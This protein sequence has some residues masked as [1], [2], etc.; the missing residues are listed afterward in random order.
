MAGIDLSVSGLAS[1]FDW[2]NI[3]DQLTEVERQPQKAVLT[4]QANIAKRR[5]ALGQISTRLTDLKTK[6]EALQQAS[7]YTGRTAST[8]DD[9]V[10]TASATNSAITGGFQVTV[11]SMAKAAS[12]KSSNSGIFSQVHGSDITRNTNASS[13]PTLGS[14]NWGPTLSTGTLSLSVKNPTTQGVVTA[15]IQVSSSDTLADIFDDIYQATGIEAT[16]SAATDKVTFTPPAGT[17]IILGA[18]NDTSNLLGCL[19][20]FT[21]STAGQSAVSSSG[22][23]SLRLGST[24]ASQPLSTPIAP[25]T[26]TFTINGTS[27]SYSTSSTLASLI[28]DINDSSAGVVATYDQSENCIV[29]RNKEPG[30]RGITVADTSPGNLMSALGLLS[31]SLTEGSDLEFSI[32]GGATQRSRSNTITET[33]SG[34]TGITFTAKKTGTA[35]VT[36]A[37]DTATMSKAITDLV[38]AASNVQSLISS[39]TVSNRDAS[40]KVTSGILAYDQTVFQL[41]S[42]LRSLMMPQISGPSTVIRSLEDLGFSTS[43]YSNEIKVSN[44][45]KLKDAL[46]ANLSEVKAFLA[47]SSTGLAAKIAA[48]AGPMVDDISGTIPSRQKALTE[49][50]KRLDG[51]LEAMERRVQANRERLLAS[52][53]AMEAAQAKSSQQLQFL[54]QKLANG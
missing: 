1:G 52:F 15:S 29:L 6:A 39:L 10:I 38:T 27:V 51:Q 41:G 33:E 45:G 16:Y 23:G 2:K 4:E 9:T 30:N 32:N 17:S 11:T 22:I 42:T 36:T 34:L 49:Q 12:W 19:K 18:P 21:P 26:G 50:S 3:V 28:A 8:S 14:T 13:L 5:D 54:N 7:L 43:G 40:G 25:T 24:L 53:R 35:T 44:A 48:F 37:A 31:G 20:L 47:T 46:T